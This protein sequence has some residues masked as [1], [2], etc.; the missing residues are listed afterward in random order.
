[1]TSDEPANVQQMTLFG[2]DKKFMD[3]ANKPNYRLIGQLFDTYWLMEYDEK[4]FIMDQHAAH[5]KILYE[6]TMRLLGNNEMTTQMVNP[7]I[8]LTLNM[9]ELEVLEANRG[10]LERLG[11]EMEDFG[12]N[13]V[14]VTG[15]PA[16]LPTLDE[17]G[18]LMEILDSLV[19]ENLKGSPETI[20]MKAASMSCKAAVKG[21]MHMSYTEAD[22]LVEQLMQAE[23]PYN[24]PHGRPT[25][26]SISK[27]ELE[28]K[29]KRI[30]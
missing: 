16:T 2:E 25:L 3:A 8:I 9:R 26:I 21:N 28:K 17:R 24:C 6:K 19:D 15:I 5:E 1:M 29:F 11:Y 4:L 14:K 23:N 20:T 30:V 10:I 13:E 18:L 12:G 22:R 27:Y 7:P